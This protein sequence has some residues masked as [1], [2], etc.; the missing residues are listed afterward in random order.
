[1]PKIAQ[2]PVDELQDPHILQ[3]GTVG[4]RSEIKYG[5][6]VNIDIG[7]EK[8]SIYVDIANFNQYEMII[9]TPFMRQN[10]VVLDFKN[11]EVLIKGKRIPAVAVSAKEAERFARRQRATDK[12][13]E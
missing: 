1:L 2:I 12:K 6:D 13:E 8:M 10:Q 7:G 9:G 5:A 3:L 11:D 4:S